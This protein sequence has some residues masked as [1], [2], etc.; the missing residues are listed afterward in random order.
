MLE[1]LKE[2]VCQANIELKN[3]KLAIFTWG[4]VSAI[5]RER[6]MF[7]IKPSGVAYDDLT[8]GRM[9]VVDLEG[10]VV[11]GDL[12]PSSDTPTHL[13]LYRCFETIGGICHTHSTQATIWAQ[14]G[15]EI[16]CLGT[17]HADY[18]YGVVPVTRPMS[19]EEIRG[20]YELNTGRVIVQ[21]FKDG[22]INPEDVPAILVANHGPFTWG[23]TAAKAVENAVVLEEVARTT[24][25]ALA[26]N[27]TQQSISQTL[28]DKHYL[29]KHGRHAYY[30]QK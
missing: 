30:G 13:E 29:R 11:E 6:G 18:F 27:P 8:A 1:Q 26:L 12:H 23:K 14:S 22:E 4:N 24:A 10:N 7:V 28:L 3:S 25:A 21:R 15:R 20:E 9:V 16:P 5:D 19:D 17:T 2:T